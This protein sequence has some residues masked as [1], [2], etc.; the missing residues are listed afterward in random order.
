VT[1]ALPRLG[2]ILA[3][4]AAAAVAVGIGIGLAKDESVVRWSAYCL[5][6]AG[7]LVIGVAFLTANPPPPR[8]R[9]RKQILGEDGGDAEQ[10]YVKPLRGEVPLLV[11]GG[12]LLIVVGTIVEL[13]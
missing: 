9:Y 12:V 1:S 6:T 13:L 10:T 4:I 7:A 8:D 3:A 11:G 5:D 2:L